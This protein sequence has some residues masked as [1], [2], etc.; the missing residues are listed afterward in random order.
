MKK[1]LI[2][3]ACMLFLV[4]GLAEAVSLPLYLGNNY[5][6]PIYMDTDGTYQFDNGTDQKAVGGGSIDYS[7]LNGVALPYVYCVDL[8]TQINVPGTYTAVVTTNGTIYSNSPTLPGLVA[9]A[10]PQIAWL[11]SAYGQNGQGD[12]QGALQAA[13]WS[14]IYGSTHV[15]LDSTKNDAT[16]I[17]DY[18]A[19]LLALG[20]KTGNV[21]AFYWISPDSLETYEQ[22][23]VAPSPVP[24]PGTLALLG[25][26]LLGLALY[27]RRRVK[28]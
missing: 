24:E 15:Y 19:D 22:A 12:A 1:V 28:K 20:S 25:S 17:A 14:V 13:I 2:L 27:A 7:T 5:T 21:S 4:A 10:A 11:L 23:L 3:T 16:M 9:S 6:A 26:G 8:F 18:N